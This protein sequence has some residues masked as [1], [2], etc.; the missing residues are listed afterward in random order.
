MLYHLL[1]AVPAA[2]IMLAGGIYKVVKHRGEGHHHHGFGHRHGEATISIDSYAYHSGISHWN[3]GFKVVLSIALLLMAVIASNYYVS[4]IIILMTTFITVV[5]GDME[6]HRYVSL[7][8]IPLVFL[9]VG[10]IMILIDFSWS[11]LTGALVNLHLANFYIII[12]GKSLQTTL[13]LWGRCFGAVSALYLL[14][15]STMSNEIFAVMEKAHFPSLLVELNNMIYRNI[16]IMADTQSRM[17]NSAESRLGYVDYKTAIKTFGNS[18]SNLFIVSLKRSGGMFDAMEARCYDGSLHFLETE[19]PLTGKQLAI[20]L[21][22][23][24]YCVL[25]WVMTTLY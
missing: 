8:T 13:M 9:I 25:V 3:P 20:G 18:I 21:G 23:V 16:F 6:F 2:V 17:K 24:G 19:K 12:T 7:L 11:P 1:W 4:L 14:S 5:L 15:L 10:S 22:V